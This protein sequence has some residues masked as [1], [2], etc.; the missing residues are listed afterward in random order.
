VAWAGVAL[1][2]IEIKPAMPT[3]AIHANAAT[4]DRA[5]AVRRWLTGRE[6]LPACEKSAIE[7]IPQDIRDEFARPSR[8]V[9]NWKTQA[10]VAEDVLSPRERELNLRNPVSRRGGAADAHR[11]AGH[12]L[13]HRTDGAA[14]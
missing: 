4:K 1:E 2:S 9:C 8:A 5:P 10:Y 3:S 6:A 13:G 12:N 14:A 11:P 7:P